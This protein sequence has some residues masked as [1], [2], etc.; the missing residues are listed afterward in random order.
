MRRHDSV[1]Q[2]LILSP[3]EWR[4][5]LRAE[6]VAGGIEQDAAGVIARRVIEGLVRGYLGGRLDPPATHQLDE[7][8]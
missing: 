5:V 2:R 3:P 1:Q 4:Q 8:A 7:A 6:L